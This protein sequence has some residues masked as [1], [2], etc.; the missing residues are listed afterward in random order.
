MKTDIL[1]LYA[2]IGSGHRRAAEATAEAL[3]GQY[4]L[5]CRVEDALAVVWP[6]LPVVANN[7]Y[8]L[9]LK[10]FP[11]WYDQMWGD[12]EAQESLGRALHQS[13]LVRLMRQLVAEAAPKACVCTHALPG[14]VLSW[15]W[16]E[17]NGRFPPITHIA[18]D[19]LA[20]GLWPVGGTDAFVVATEQAAQ[21]MAGRG[22]APERIHT[23]GIPIAAHFNRPHP[24]QAELRHQLGLKDRPTLL[25]LTGS[26]NAGPYAEFAQTMLRLFAHWAANPPANPP[27]IIVITGNN[28][29]NLAGLQAFA[30]YLP[31][32][33]KLLPFV[34]NMADWMLASDL[35]LT[36]PGGLTAAESLA[37]GLPLLL[38]GVGPGQEHA[39]ANW[40]LAEECAVMGE[41]AVAALA[42][43]IETLLAS[44]THLARL[45]ANC[46]RHARPQAAKEI[47]ELIMVNC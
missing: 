17:A 12:D 14:R 36:K 45:R 25:A 5:S 27:Q 39:N 6:R 10:F 38:R 2:A 3:T 24:A 23:L 32:P 28:R 46:L 31:F 19:F 42:T 15:A 8:A 11:S 33:V 7:L 4:G 16:L 21:Q 43:Q 13:D 37:C 44:P 26:W 18:T 40:L 29:E 30:P 20:N 47:A 34:E 35:L 22:L 9:T 1:V 41:T